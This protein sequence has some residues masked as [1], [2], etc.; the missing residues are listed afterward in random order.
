MRSQLNA[1]SKHS[2]KPGIMLGH[3]KPTPDRLKMLRATISASVRGAASS[4]S[5]TGEPPDDR[6]AIPQ[7]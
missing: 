7:R 6:N 5:D 2:A 1:I 4:T 3:A